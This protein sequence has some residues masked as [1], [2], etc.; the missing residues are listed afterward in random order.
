[1]KNRRRTW[2]IPQDLR[3]AHGGEA[4]KTRSQVGLVMFLCVAILQCA[5]QQTSPIKLLYNPVLSIDP[6]SG[7]GQ[8]KVL[9]HN[10]S[11]KLASV[12]LYVAPPSTEQSSPMIVHVFDENGVEHI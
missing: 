12:S 6:A 4:M 1:M 10:G 8:T 11:S 9:L 5:A 7:S 3:N 2:E